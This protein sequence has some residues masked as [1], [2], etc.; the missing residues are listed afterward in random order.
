M[1]KHTTTTDAGRWATDGDI[2]AKVIRI[3][4]TGVKDSDVLLDNPLG[5]VPTGIQ[6]IL[7]DKDCD[8]VHVN[9]TRSKIV[10]KFTADNANINLRVW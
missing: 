9:S 6:I 5:R 1:I 8:V 3:S 2:D 4:D 10:V 7:K